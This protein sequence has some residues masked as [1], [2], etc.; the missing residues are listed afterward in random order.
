M[1]N[2][3]PI[4]ITVLHG[5]HVTVAEVAITDPY[6]NETLF[7]GDAKKHPSDRYDKR[8]GA[9]YAVGRALKKLSDEL[10]ETADDL[11]AHPQ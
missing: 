6:G 4:E 2:L 9:S 3:L 10:I 7:V 1:S 5:E 8:I 11:I